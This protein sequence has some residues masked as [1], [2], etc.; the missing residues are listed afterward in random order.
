VLSNVSRSYHQISR[1]LATPDEIMRLKSPTQF[2]TA[3]GYYATALHELGHWT[4]HETR[5]NRDLGHPFGSEG[6]A[7]DELR[8]EIASL[9]LGDRLGLGH[10]G[11][12]MT[13]TLMKRPLCFH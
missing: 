4:G 13:D 8:A 12:R 11:A 2:P 9:M 7:R 10:D 1:P 6:Y 5:L 3:D